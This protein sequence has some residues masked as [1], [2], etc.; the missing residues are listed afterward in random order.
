MRERDARCVRQT[1]VHP[2]AMALPSIVRRFE[3]ALSDSDRSVY[4]S[5][6][7]RVAQHPSESPRYL[8]ARV[9]ARC[10]E[11]AEGVDFSAGL[12]A[13]DEPA[14]WQRDLQGT[15]Q[16]WIEVGSP[17]AE[18]LHRA[19]KACKR[20]VVYAWARATELARDAASFNGKGIHRASELEVYAIDQGFLDAVSETLDRNNHW[21]ISVTGSVVYLEAGSKLFECAIERAFVGA[22]RSI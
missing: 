15:L 21:S 11:H 8:V 6:D 9:L 19:S 10:L 17:S 14:L 7:L 4:E 5:L 1:V 18:R 13:A 12:S 22:A 3:I 16:A 20:T 2:R